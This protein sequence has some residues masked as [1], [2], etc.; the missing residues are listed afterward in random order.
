MGGYMPTYR[1]IGEHFGFSAKCAYDY[2]SVLVGKGYL[3]RE[4]MRP[5]RLHFVP[6]LRIAVCDVPGVKI[7]KGDYVHVYGNVVTAITR[8]F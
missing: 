4:R 2:I 5:R 7:H 3:K 6:E 8:A 1:E